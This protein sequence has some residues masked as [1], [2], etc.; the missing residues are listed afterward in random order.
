MLV[1]VWR[2]SSEGGEVIEEPGLSLV[3]L[4]RDAWAFLTVSGLIES[5]ELGVSSQESRV[6]SLESGLM[7]LK[8][9]EEWRAE[10]EARAL[11]AGRRYGGIGF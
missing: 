11:A 2:P 7:D 8:V 3:L 10:C 6:G 9:H 4:V 5:L 1:C